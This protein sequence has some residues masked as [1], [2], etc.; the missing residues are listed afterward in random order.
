[1]NIKIE[2]KDASTFWDMLRRS[3]EDLGS[4]IDGNTCH[5]HEVGKSESAEDTILEYARFLTF[6]RKLNLIYG[7]R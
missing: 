1:M 2:D 5:L 3:V 4:A 7:K 6:Y